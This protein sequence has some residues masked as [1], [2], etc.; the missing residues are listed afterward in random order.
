MVFIRNNKIQ[1]M[2]HLKRFW[3]WL[4][5]KTTIDEKIE[6]KVDEVV[7]EVKE[8]VDR[9]KEEIADVKEAASEVISQAG[10]VVDAAKGK[11]RRGRKKKK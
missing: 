7:E 6:A 5:G 8:R 1:K 9:I 10:D 4:L 2:K 3:H 11:K